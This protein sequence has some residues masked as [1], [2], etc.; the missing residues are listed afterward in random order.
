[1]RRASNPTR[2]IR[3]FT[4]MEVMVA[5]AIAL[6]ALEV[7]FGGVIGSLRTA[8]D[9]SAWE[10]AISRAQSHLTA[11]IDPGRALG[12]REGDD[13]DGYRWRTQVSLLGSAPAPPG[14]R[15]GQWSRGTALYGISVTVFWRDGRA[16]RRF[17]LNSAELGP[18]PHRDNGP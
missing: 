12:E 18:I 14:A 8:H 3:G 7:L 13:G 15:S 2:K 10:R 6:I 5:L 4:L 1:M 17:V 9:T 11:T 16:E